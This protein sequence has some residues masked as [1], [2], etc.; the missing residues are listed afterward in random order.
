MNSQPCPVCGVE[1]ERG[2][3]TITLMYKDESTSFEMPGWYCPGCGEGIHSGQDMQESDKQLNLLKAKAEHL[4]LPQDVRRIRK[5]LMLT[6]EKAGQ[7]LGGG[8]NAFNKYEKGLILPSQAVSNLLRVLDAYPD[9]MSAL[10]FV[11]R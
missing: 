9:S 6:Q 2:V 7:L 3:K 1:M 4:L 5:Q 10:N 11:A 8:P